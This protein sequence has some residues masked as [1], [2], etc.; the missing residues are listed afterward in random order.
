MGIKWWQHHIH[1][2]VERVTVKVALQ[3][4]FA[5]LEQVS[6]CWCFAAV[7]AFRAQVKIVANLALIAWTMKISRPAPIVNE[8]PQA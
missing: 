3:Y 5:T 4:P 7:M 1:C 8:T 6:V 2:V